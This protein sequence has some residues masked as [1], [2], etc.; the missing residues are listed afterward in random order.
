MPLAPLPLI[1]IPHLSSPLPTLSPLEQHNNDHLV[2]FA[3]LFTR[4]SRRERAGG[5]EGD[6]EGCW[7]GNEPFSAGGAVLALAGWRSTG[8]SYSSLSSSC[9]RS[10]VDPMRCR[11]S[12][13]SPSRSLSPSKPKLTWLLPFQ[14]LLHRRQLH[15][16]SRL[17]PGSS[18][19]P[20]LCSPPSS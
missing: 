5:C 15:L 16:R 2:S 9:G 6:V 12:S 1:S 20:R 18:D 17:L 8:L 10:D 13:P 19:F 14:L 3:F 4:W 11:L 7:R